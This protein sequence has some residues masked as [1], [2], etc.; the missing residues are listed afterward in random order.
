VKKVFWGLIGSHLLFIFSGVLFST[1]WIIAEKGSES[2]AGIFIGS[3]F[4]FGLAGVLIAL[5]CIKALI[6][7]VT[8]ARLRPSHVL[9]FCLALFVAVSIIT[10]GF[11]GRAFTSELPLV[12][13]WAGIE[14]IAIL[15]AFQGEWLS[16]F[17]AIVSSAIV[18]VALVTGLFCYSIHYILEGA[19]RFINGLVPYAVIVF[20]MIVLIT[21]LL[22]GYKEIRETEVDR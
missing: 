16:K 8:H 17:R 6:Q 10:S 13:I 19:A 20:T 14:W 5:N 21:I 18:T 22:P 3:S 9:V 2:D 11:M 12:L 1:Y 4:L 7:V 15:L